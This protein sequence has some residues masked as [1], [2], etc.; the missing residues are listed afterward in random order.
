MLHFGPN[1]S[2]C[3]CLFLVLSEITSDSLSGWL[4]IC[5]IIFCFLFV[6]NTNQEQTSISFFFVMAQKFSL[7]NLSWPTFPLSFDFEKTLSSVISQMKDCWLSN[8]HGAAFL[9]VSFPKCGLPWCCQGFIISLLS[10]HALRSAG[11]MCLFSWML[12]GCLEILIDHTFKV[13]SRYKD[14]STVSYIAE[15]TCIII[16]LNSV[17]IIFLLCF[18][19]R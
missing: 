6:S 2:R 5:A 16:I 7:F 11:Q 17:M 10:P 18:V 15:I 8:Q 13:S 4:K 12:S 1:W 9:S 19:F 3:L 14:I